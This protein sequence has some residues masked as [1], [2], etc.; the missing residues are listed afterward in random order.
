MAADSKVVKSRYFK[1]EK[2]NSFVTNLA[3][4]VATSIMLVVSIN[5]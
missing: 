5:L 1:V 2:L 3:S 4:I